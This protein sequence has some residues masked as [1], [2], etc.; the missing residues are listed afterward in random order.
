MAKRSARRKHGKSTRGKARKST[1]TKSRRSVRSKPRKSNLPRQ[2]PT[3]E[4]VEQIWK[5][6]VAPQILPDLKTL[7]ENLRMLEEARKQAQNLVAW[8]DRHDKKLEAYILTAI[9]NL[10]AQAAYE[11]NILKVLLFRVGG[12]MV[13]IALLAGKPGLPRSVPP[14]MEVSLLN[15]RD[16][17]VK[18]IET[19]QA[20]IEAAEKLALHF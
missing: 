9:S 8:A 5:E 2:S 10:N 7:D 12:I 14:E 15:L 16:M 6:Q 11:A 4:T 19:N 18:T 17:I 1:R 13:D 3:A 20:S